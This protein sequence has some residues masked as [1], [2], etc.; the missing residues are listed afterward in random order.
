[1][2]FDAINLYGHSMREFL[3]THGFEWMDVET[4]S[5]EEWNDFILNQ[6]AEQ[7]T[8]Y[9]FLCDLSYPSH[10]QWTKS[11][12]A[13]FGGAIFDLFLLI[14]SIV[15]RCGTSL[16]PKLRTYGVGFSKFNKV[17]DTLTKL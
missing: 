13:N 7:D 11:S 9:I 6:N 17:G 5:L 3:P 8:G 12:R 1:M 16:G 2:Y 14:K 15:L 10:L 4:K